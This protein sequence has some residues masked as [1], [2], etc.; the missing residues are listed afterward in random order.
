MKSGCLTTDFSAP[1]FPPANAPG[2]GG[3]WSFGGARARGARLVLA[4]AALLFLAPLAIVP[5]IRGLREPIQDRSRRQRLHACVV[6]HSP[7]STCWGT[8]GGVQS[9]C[10]QYGTVVA[11]VDIVTFNDLTINMT[12]SAQYTYENCAVDT[13]DI[14]CCI[15]QSDLC[16]KSQVEA[17]NGW[18]THYVSS[19]N[20]FASQNVSTHE[21]RYEYCEDNSG[22]V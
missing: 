6:G 10:S 2:A 13:R 8:R 22:S 19:N 18:I 12:T 21:L 1:A 7:N 17:T 9:D 3:G 11:K 14:S 20:T 5:A 16:K 15:D 4:C